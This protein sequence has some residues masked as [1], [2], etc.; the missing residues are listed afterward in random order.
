VQMERAKGL[1]GK[2]DGDTKN[3]PQHLPVAGS[4]ATD[5]R[6]VLGGAELSVRKFGTESLDILQEKARVRRA[7]R[8]I[9]R[10]TKSVR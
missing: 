7:R 2:L 5:A 9:I 6:L 1:K 8:E 10:P 4:S 3:S